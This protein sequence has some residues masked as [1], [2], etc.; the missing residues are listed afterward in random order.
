M[1]RPVHPEAADT[2]VCVGNMWACDFPK[3]GW[4]SKRLGKVSYDCDGTRIPTFRP[5]FVTRS[6]VEAAGVEIP[7][8][9]P[10]DH[11]W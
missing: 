2:E 6:E 9:G 4:K 1:A 8:V 3:V 10:V 5:V 7:D 11:R